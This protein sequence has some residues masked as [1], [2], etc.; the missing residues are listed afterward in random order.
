MRFAFMT[1]SCSD[2]PLGEVLGIARRLGYDGV[3]PRLGAD[4]AHGVEPETGADARREIRKTVEA[5]GVALA[6][7]AT[8][9]RLADPEQRDQWMDYARRTIDLAGDLNVPAIRVFGGGK[10]GEEFSR[11]RAV[12]LLADSLGRLAP[13]AAERGTA[14]CV[15]T[16]DAWSDPVDLAAALKRVYHPAAAANWDIMHPVRHASRTMDEAFE[17]L[18]PWIR[19]VHLHDGILGKPAKGE[20]LLR[21]IGEGAIDHRR[22]LELLAGADYAGYLSGEWIGGKNWDP[23]EVHLPRELATL[24]GYLADIEDAQ[25]TGS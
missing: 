3:E 4:H 17:A 5:S 13:E 16:H 21:P 20:G 23:W 8:S 14:L 9:C 1:F 15:E 2:L 19:H 10:I 25:S 12:D 6:C 18:R 22:A 7:L 24:K 11:E